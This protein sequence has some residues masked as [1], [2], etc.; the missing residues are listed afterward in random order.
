MDNS[1]PT[2]WINH[3]INH[4]ADESLVKKERIGRE[5]LNINY[6]SVLLE[7]NDYRDL[8]DKEDK[9]YA[10]ALYRIRTTEEAIN[11]NKNR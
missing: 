1:F 5:I 8:T 9:A 11:K 10:E 3:V 7:G 2:K 4:Y 6:E